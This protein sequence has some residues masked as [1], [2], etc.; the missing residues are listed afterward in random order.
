MADTLDKLACPACGEEMKKI[1][2]QEAGVNI[3]L[4][5]NGCGG[6]FFDNREFEK[7]DEPDENIIN[8]L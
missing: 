5:L 6:I 4:C 1:Y 2:M 8:L 7:F 3:D